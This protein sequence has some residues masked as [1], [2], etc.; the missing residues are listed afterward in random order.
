MVNKLRVKWIF[1]SIGVI[2]TACTLSTAQVAQVITPTDPPQVAASPTADYETWQMIAPGLEQRIYIPEDTEILAM[3]ALRID[4]TQYQFRVH[5]T[6]GDASSLTEWLDQLPEPVALVNANFFDPQNNALGLL[7]SDGQVFGSSYR[8]RGG[9]FGILNGMPTVR[10]N[11]AQPYA[12][13]PYE[14]AIQAFPMLVLNG[15][16]AYTNSRDTRRSRRTVIG[17]DA[18]GRIILMAT[19]GL[20]LSLYELSEYLPTTDLGLV[21]AFN[22]DGGG[23]TMMWIADSDTRIFSFDPVPAVLAVYSVE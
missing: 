19:P 10:S 16:Q 5:Y 4:P 12:D 21:N 6:P 13:E 9:T 18:Q 23:S 15:A 2:L 17:Q 11:I 14:Q 20:G 22:L 3:V 7:V 8:D 1:S